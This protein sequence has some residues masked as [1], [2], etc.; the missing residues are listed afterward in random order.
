[1]KQAQ[2]ISQLMKQD[3]TKLTPWIEGE[4]TQ[5][6]LQSGAPSINVMATEDELLPFSSTFIMTVLRAEGFDVK[7][8]CQ[9]RPCT[10]PY[11]AITIPPQ[12]K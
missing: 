2:K 8:V 4:L 3:L 1:M 11:Y 7:Y 12:G 10:P 6:F 9:D 5:K